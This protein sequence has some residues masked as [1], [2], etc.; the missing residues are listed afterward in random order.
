MTVYKRVR[1]MPEKGVNTRY[2]REIPG[3]TDPFGEKKTTR[4]M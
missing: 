3:G 1:R 4:L 2:A